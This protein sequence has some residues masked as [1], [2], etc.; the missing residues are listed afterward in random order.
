[1]PGRGYLKA[2]LRESRKRK[3]FSGR[4]NETIFIQ[5]ETKKTRNKGGWR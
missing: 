3:K 4:N 2:K 5:H 1:V